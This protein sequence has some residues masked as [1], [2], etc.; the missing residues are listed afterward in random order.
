LDSVTNHP[1]N[2]LNNFTKDKLRYAQHLEHSVLGPRQDRVFMATMTTTF[3]HEYSDGTR[4]VEEIV[5]AGLG[6]SKKESEFYAAVDLIAGLQSEFG[7]D[8][9]NPPDYKAAQQRRE[10][11]RFQTRLVRAQMLLELLGSSRP[12]FEF[13][14]AHEKGGWRATASVWVRGAFFDTQGPRGKNK[15]QAEGLALLDIVEGP[16]LSAHLGPRAPAQYDAVIDASPARQVSS[17]QIPP[18]PYE[19]AH[20]L[21]ETVGPFN[22][23]HDQRMGDLAAAQE[24]FELRRRGDG[25]AAFGGRRQGRRARS[26]E[27]RAES[28]NVWLQDEERKRERLA[29]QHPDGKQAAMLALREALPIGQIREPLLRALQVG[30]VAVVSG[31]TGSGKSTQCPQYILEDAILNLN[32]AQTEIIVTQ[33]RKIAAVSVAQRVAAERDEEVGNSVGYTV[34]FSRKA[35]REA[36]GTIEFVTTG[37]LLRRITNDP[38][39]DGVSHVIIDEV[40]ERDINTDFLLIL[41]RDLIKKRPDLRVVLMSATLNAESFAQYFSSEQNNEGQECQ[42]LSVPTQP[43]HPVEVFYLE[44]MISEE[45]EGSSATAAFPSSM[46]DLAKSLLRYHDEKL[47]IELEEA[48]SEVSAAAQLENYSNAEDAG[49]L[50]DSDTD[51]EDYSDSELETE[52]DESLLQPSPSAVSRI[53]TLKRAVSMRQDDGAALLSSPLKTKTKAEERDA[54]DSIVKLVAK[55]AWNLS[56]VEIDAGRKGSIL[57]FLPGWD[58]IKA[59]TSLLEEK[60]T[61]ENHIAAKINIL[62]LH[63]TIPQEDQQKVF[64]PAEEGAVKVILSTNIAE[65]SITIDD[66]LA[67]V[68]GGLVRELRWDAESAMSTMETVPTSRA[69]ATQRL[70]RA[71]RVAPG[72]CYRLYSRGVFETMAERPAPEIQRTALEA[73]CLQTCAMVQDGIAQFLDRAMDPPSADAVTF[74][75]ERLVKLGA[76]RVEKDTPGSGEVLTPLGRSLSQLPLDPATGRMLLMGVVMRC[77]GPVV[78][79]AACFSSRSVFYN[80]PGLRDEAQDIRKSFSLSSDTVAQI[81]AYNEFWDIEKETGWDAACSWARQNYVSI[82]AMISIKAVRSQLLNELKKIGL[83]DSYD[84]ERVGYKTYALRNDAMANWNSDNELLHTAVLASGLPGNISSRRQLGAFGTLRTRTENHAGLHPSSVSFHRKPPKG[85][86]KLPSWYLYREMVLSSQV[87]L[88]ECTSMTPEQIVL[89]GGYSLDSFNNQHPAGGYT[90]SLNVL[91][92]WIVAESQC[93]DTLNVLISARRDINAALEYKAMHPRAHL[94][95]ESQVVIDSICDMFQVL[96]EE[97]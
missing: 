66:V 26:R 75:V 16:D 52:P 32:G 89:F 42:L 30:Q 97:R 36:G 38:M 84:L 58:E 54:E 18:L 55:L 24:D 95:D 27:T 5:C 94:P 2:V 13:P 40:H 71:G 14:D 43:R 10:E 69:S 88:R 86:V 76:L 21:V 49:L 93:D 87:F 60:A 57:C 37:V 19:V 64:K 1:K 59:A 56:K 31:G 63:S 22:G 20:G 17:L 35:P 61:A 70:G 91:D 41:L 85:G 90:H 62:P 6:K 79:A 51:L 73:T 77:L 29:A 15:A 74:A 44:D 12:R 25:P 72:R 78:T 53:E 7:I 67:V 4:T 8:A 45:G 81:S 39:L 46:R 33:P 34:R 83:V 3:K 9:R 11:E 92:N 96:S 82:A 50:L 65:S 68:D 48:K 80:P 28:I 47:L 23:R